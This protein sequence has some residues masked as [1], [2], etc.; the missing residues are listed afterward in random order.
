[1]TE[2]QDQ[3]ASPLLHC[4]VK[5]S[6]QVLTE[7]DWK[8]NAAEN[9]ALAT[10]ATLALATFVTFVALAPFATLAAFALATFVTFVALAP[11]VTFVFDNTSIWYYI[12]RFPG[13]V[14]HHYRKKELN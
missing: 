12:F 2:D 3:K 13:A 6:Q 8:S 4:T 9:L 10:F 14:W 5:K 7:E 11:F 1:M